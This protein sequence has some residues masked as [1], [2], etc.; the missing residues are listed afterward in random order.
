VGGKVLDRVAR[1]NFD[2][3]AYAIDRFSRIWIPLFPALLLTA[4]IA[5][6]RG[7]PVSFSEF[8]GNLFGLQGL[9]CDNFGRN[10]PLWSLAYEIWFYFLAGCAAIAVSHSPR[11]FY[12]YIGLAIGLGVFTRLEPTMLYIWILGAISYRFIHIRFNWKIVL[13]GLF[14]VIAG[15]LMTQLKLETTS[16]N[17]NYIQRF[18]PSQNVTILVLGFGLTLI[19]PFLS[20]LRPHSDAT[21][22]FERLGSHLAAMSYTL[23][24]THYPLLGLWEYFFPQR[25]QTL[26]IASFILF[27]GK[28][29][30]C[31]IVAWLLYLPFEARTASVRSWLRKRL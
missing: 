29:L 27:F 16:L 18:I 3:K 13:T 2:V 14:L 1:G 26:H 8:I 9:I 5:Y 20:R 17:I 28:I 23:Y 6:V 11:K 31:L 21:A 12:A 30:S 7:F 25:I 15:I 24:L 19:L 22:A 10:V 4:G